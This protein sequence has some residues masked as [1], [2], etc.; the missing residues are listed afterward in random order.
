VTTA[1]VLALAGHY[2]V[3]QASAA[4]SAR[5][6]F[7][8]YA[9]AARWLTHNSPEGAVVFT[10]DWDDFPEL[11]FFNRHN[12]YL[13]GLDPTYS[14]LYWPDAYRRWE[15]IARGDLEDVEELRSLWNA[16]YVFTDREHRAFYRG[17][18]KL[19]GVELV[20]QDEHALVYRLSSESE[21]EP[22]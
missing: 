11:F 21:A 19:R 14:F 12:R 3:A 5:P 7:D 20:Y 18:E 9:G 10:S 1:L 16:D 22:P 2:A 6:P 17:L 8:R 4:L 15:E 13:A